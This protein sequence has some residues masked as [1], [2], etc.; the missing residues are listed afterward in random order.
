MDFLTDC[1]IGFMV[2]GGCIAFM[3][4]I[5]AAAGDFTRD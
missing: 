5:V 2:F 4:F 3:C 1:A